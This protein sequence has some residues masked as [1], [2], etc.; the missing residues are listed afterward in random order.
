MTRVA[1]ANPA[2]WVDI[3]LDNRH[4]LLDAL[5]AHRE[6][7]ERLEAM[8]VAADR[9]ALETWIEEAA[10]SRERVYARPPSSGSP[11]A[12]HSSLPPG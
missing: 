6:A 2:I 3:F 8:L 12:F 9:D 1:G 10:T 5:A 7:I 4:E 11:A